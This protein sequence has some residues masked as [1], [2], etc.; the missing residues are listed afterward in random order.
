ML[1]QK[2]QHDFLFR[3]NS[4]EKKC[5]L[6]LIQLRITALLNL[7]NQFLGQTAECISPL[8]YPVIFL[9]H[10]LGESNSGRKVYCNL[11]I[12]VIGISA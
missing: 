12:L 11:V 4:K 1:I 10:E 9:D 6:G 5:Y 3:N 7:D 2:S 8:I